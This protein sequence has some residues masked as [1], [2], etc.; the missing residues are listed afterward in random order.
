[1]FLAIKCIDSDYTPRFFALC[2]SSAA[3]LIWGYLEMIPRVW[4]HSTDSILYLLLPASNCAIPEVTQPW[5]QSPRRY[6]AFVST[7]N[8]SAQQ[9]SPGIQVSRRAGIRAK[10]LFARHLL[11]N[12]YIP[13]DPMNSPTA[14]GIA[15]TGAFSLQVFLILIRL[16]H[17]RRN[18]HRMN[19]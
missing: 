9:S 13:Y 18:R 11:F 14:S 5:S 1:M 15:L 19:E 6:P 17:F 16:R 12:S 4:N 7:G 10:C 8:Y 3:H 2:Q